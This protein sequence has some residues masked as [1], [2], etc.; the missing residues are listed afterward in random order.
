MKKNILLVLITVLVGT[1]AIGQI[2]RSKPPKPQPNPEININIPEVVEM[3]NGMKLIVVENHKL[4]KVTFQLFVDYPTIPEGD[5]AGLSDIFGELLGSGTESLSKDEFDA[6][7]DYMGATLTTSASGIYAS[8]LTKH[9]P[10][11]LDLM[12]QVVLQPA[13]PEDEFDRIIKQNISAIASE[14]SD[15]SAMASNVSGVVNYGK[16]HPYGEIVTEKSLESI[17]LSDVKNHYQTYFRPNYAYMIVVGDITPE[18]AKNM[19][20]EHFNEWEVGEDLSQEEFAIPTNEGNNV[21]FVDKPGAVQSQISITHTLDLPPGHQDEIKLKMLNQILGGGS[22]SAR[23]MSNLREDK[24]YT[25]GCYSRIS[26]DELCGSFTA[27]GS[28]RNEVTDSA[29]VEIMSEIAKIAANDVEDEELELAKSSMT[30]SFAR[31]LENPQTVARFAL[32]TAK[33]DLESDYYTKYLTQLEAIS[34]EDLREVAKKYLR[35]ENLNIVVVGNSEIAEKLE[36]F[37][38]NNGIERRDAYGEEVLMLKAAPDDVTVQSIIQKYMYKICSVESVKD[39]NKF[40]K[41]FGYLEMQYSAEMT[42]Q[43]TTAKIILTQYKGK[44]NMTA[45]KMK[46]EAPGQ[47]MIAQKEWFNGEEG[48][49]YIMMQGVTKYEGEELEAKKTATFPFDQFHYIEN[50]KLKIELLGVDELDGVE[51]FKLKITEEG[52]EKIT[53]EY[54]SVESGW[55]V[56]Q[57]TFDTDDE[58]NSVTSVIMYGDYKE[59]K[60]GLMLPYSMTI[61]SNGQ[62][63][64]ATLDYAEMGKKPKSP[65]FDG[66]FK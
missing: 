4:P 25:Y 62:K 16:N 47:S 7:V 2:D 66:D 6:K 60:K 27:G 3:N 58:G 28:F 21:Y 8:S 33:Y 18:E 22:F 54:Y 14:E 38:T 63:I 56:K 52:S 20:E 53:H 17:T 40:M 10:K 29:I 45:S 61:V 42:M 34:K 51:V 36:K 19:V 50:D 12:K 64:E 41:K 39:Y 48:G 30:G 11:L 37:D 26:S 32:N 15:P 55:L 49:T 31:S 44:P 43:G 65:A 59:V 35:P 23:L 9:T 5:K 1:T 13:F 46:I 24:A 57:E